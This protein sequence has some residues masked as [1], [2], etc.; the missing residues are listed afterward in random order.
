MARK[1]VHNAHKAW[2]VVA[3]VHSQ[4]FNRNR[5]RNCNCNVIIAAADF[6]SKW[7][8]MDGNRDENELSTCWQLAVHSAFTGLQK[9]IWYNMPSK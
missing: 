2:R 4:F 6:F 5:N 1:Y 8:N 7:L 3:R 9:C